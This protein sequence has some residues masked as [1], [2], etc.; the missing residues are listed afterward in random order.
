MDLVSK[1]KC[2]LIVHGTY[3]ITVQWRVHLISQY[4]F[5]SYTTLK[6][7]TR[8]QQFFSALGHTQH[9]LSHS[10]F[11]LSFTLLQY[12]LYV[13][14]LFCW[15]GGFVTPILC[16]NFCTRLHVTVVTGRV[17]LCF[18]GLI[19]LTCSSRVI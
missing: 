8:R 16:F 3:I 13:S 11:Y 4:L 6:Y 15:C 2:F 12:T 9:F 19:L 10:Q 17:F 14:Y 18:T 1:S 5:Y 7:F